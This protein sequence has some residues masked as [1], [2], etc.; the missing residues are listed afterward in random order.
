[1]PKHPPPSGARL[2]KRL[3]P[4]ENHDALLG[5]L[6]EEYQRDRSVWWYRSQIVAAIVVGS[7]R[8]V[9]RQWVLSL[10]A[11]VVGA[12]AF[13]AYFYVVAIL[14]LNNVRWIRLPGLPGFFVMTSVLFL[15][16]FAASGWTIVRSHRRYGIASAMPFAALMAVLW[17]ADV[18]RIASTP[19]PWTTFE[20]LF[21]LLIKPLFP[22]SVL[23]GGYSATRR[24]GPA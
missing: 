14:I 13:L 22:F 17:L 20:T 8:N 11:I 5:D 21:T 6:C 18:A 12:A 15:A 7:L 1:M 3:V 16:G 24:V 10:R 9:R 23:L 2:L 4:H 19:H